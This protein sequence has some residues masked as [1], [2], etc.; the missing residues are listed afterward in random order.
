ML[1]FFELDN[2]SSV[3]FIQ[4]DELI[5]FIVS[6]LCEFFNIPPKKLSCSIS[7]TLYFV[8]I[9]FRAAIKPLNPAPIITIS[10]L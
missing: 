6:T 7:K 4:S 5:P 2:S 3:S 1:I 8:L 10:V 9:N